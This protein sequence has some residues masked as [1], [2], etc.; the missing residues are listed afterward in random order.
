MSD[1][2]NMLVQRERG[3]AANAITPRLPSR[4]EPMGAITPVTPTEPDTRPSGEATLGA[5]DEATPTPINRAWDLTDARKTDSRPHSHGQVRARTSTGTSDAQSVHADAHGTGRVQDEVSTIEHGGA[6][7][8][9]ELVPTLGKDTANKPPA[10][11]LSSVE[12]AM[13]TGEMED[14]EAKPLHLPKRQV[15]R[16]PEISGLNSIDS[17]STGSSRE[18]FRKRAVPT[19]PAAGRITQESTQ[20]PQHMTPANETS[21]LPASNA[22]ADEPH[23]ASIPKRGGLARPR[24]LTS[25]DNQEEAPVTEPARTAKSRAVDSRQRGA[26]DRIGEARRK[27][28]KNAGSEPVTGPL[29]KLPLKIE[30]EQGAQPSVAASRD[31]YTPTKA[32]TAEVAVI[33]QAQPASRNDSSIRPNPPTSEEGFPPR[34]TVRTSSDIS[35]VRP[36]PRSPQALLVGEHETSAVQPTINVTIGR[37][38]VRAVAA[39]TTPKRRNA[40]PKPMSLEEYLSQHSGRSSRGGSR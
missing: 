15:E 6:A 23:T 24:D 11:D 40:A 22:R 29:Q 36:P 31:A 39:P 16:P 34:V 21:T 4:Y 28:H 19:E 1:F 17:I 3:Q 26:I 10:Q 32:L 8:P 30:L 13:A 38:E 14:T 33:K 12:S 37:I 7:A 20:D 35:P 18:Q 27:D 9:M 2:L 25:R 5:V